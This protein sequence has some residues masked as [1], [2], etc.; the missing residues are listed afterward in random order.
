MTRLDDPDRDLDVATRRV[1][2]LA[3]SDP[4]GAYYPG[5]TTAA[6]EY[7]D[8]TQW[9]I[10]GL[11]LGLLAF[12]LVAGAAGILATAQ[13]AGRQARESARADH[14]LA[15]IGMSRRQRLLV[16]ALPVIGAGLVGVALGAG[17]AVA[18]SPVL[19]RGRARLAEV[20]PGV[21]IDP[22]VFGA[23]IFVLLTIIAAIALLVAARTTRPASPRVLTGRTT[24]VNRTITSFGLRPVAATGLRRAS[25]ARGSRGSP[26]TRS[27]MTGMAVAIAGIV[28]A[29]VVVQSADALESD[30]ANWGWVWT[31]RPDVFG[32]GDPMESAVADDDVASA[33]IL[34]SV[35]VVI[36]DRE[37][38][39]M[40]LASYKGDLAFTLVRGRLPSSPA[41]VALGSETLADLGLEIGDS[42]EALAAD[43]ATAHSLQVV[44]T[45]VLPQ[46][47]LATLDQGAVFTPDGLD[48]LAQAPPSLEPVI[49]Y[50]DG[51]DV[52][53]LEQRLT[54]AAGLAFPVFSARVPGSITNVVESSNISWALAGFFLIIG[55]VGLTNALTTSIRR[56]G[57][58]F[59]VLR[60]LG[61]RG[62]QV[63]QATLVQALSLS[64]VGVVVG[65][66]LGLIGGRA[67]WRALSY[68]LRIGAEP[69]MPWALTL[70][71]IPATA[72]VTALLCWWPG[73]VAA[74]S[75]PAV[76]L[77]AE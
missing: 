28:A 10:D 68:D 61:F 42:V 63:R 59:A 20:E 34:S 69:T 49:G 35:S 26:A 11:A 73:R 77:R 7:I 57:H 66:P 62:R 41:E 13:S 31:T 54:D 8:T 60:A 29:G 56:D 27:A 16:I 18:L 1:N 15:A 36:D 72:I 44:G 64:A 5:S 70:G 30:P 46:T 2:S 71:V 45:A 33:G 24:M 23:G 50:R 65:V 58:E 12:A 37:L 74:R 55:M 51:A 52:A 22:I 6:D 76:L 38:Q 43:G 19:P 67:A 21:W 40:S 9:S 4:D 53:A 39:G 17:I 3:Q 75:Q 47:E 14:T 25:A 32:D 48:R